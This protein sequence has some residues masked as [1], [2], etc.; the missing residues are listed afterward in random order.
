MP[1][2][3]VTYQD[4]V[5]LIWTET[6]KS[7]GIVVVRSSEVFASWDGVSILSIGAADTLDPNDSLAQMILHELC[8]LLVE[9]P[10]AMHKP[11]WGI[12]NGNI[13]Y[14]VHEHAC[15]RLQAALADTV[16]LRSFFAATTV[17]RK[18]YDR[19]PTDPLGDGADPAI[20]LAR[21]AW[22]RSREAPFGRALDRSLA[23]TAAIAELLRPLAPETSLWSMSQG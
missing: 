21:R 9:G 20:P 11:D 12:Q 16:G 14:R 17:F 15:L 10:E 2:S 4:P 22:A 19:L 5:D 13:A 8:H 23:M 6:A 18:Y 1:I 3:A 7:L